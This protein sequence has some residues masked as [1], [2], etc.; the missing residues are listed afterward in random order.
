MYELEPG[1]IV[2]DIHRLSG[3]I[4]IVQPNGYVTQVQLIPFKVDLKPPQPP[5]VRYN[6]KAF[7]HDGTYLL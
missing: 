4:T 3:L 6:F 2:F 7:L 5:L 1:L